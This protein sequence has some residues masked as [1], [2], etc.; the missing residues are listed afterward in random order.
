MV[1]LIVIYD[2]DTAKAIGIKGFN[3]LYEDFQNDKMKNKSKDGQAN[4]GFVLD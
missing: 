2:E 4:V 1:E 3:K